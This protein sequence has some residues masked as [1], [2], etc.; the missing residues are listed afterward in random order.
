ME[1]QADKYLLYYLNKVVMLFA[2]L[3]VFFPGCTAINF[4]VGAIIDRPTNDVYEKQFKP[5][6]FHS[7]YPIKFSGKVYSGESV[8]E[9]QSC[10]GFFIKVDE[11]DQMVQL[12]HHDLTIL[13]KDGTKLFGT[14]SH[15]GYREQEPFLRLGDQSQVFAREIDSLQF[16]PVRTDSSQHFDGV[17]TYYPVPDTTYYAISGSEI[18]EF[19]LGFDVYRYNAEP[20]FIKVKEIDKVVYRKGMGPLPY[21]L[22]GVGLV[23]DVIIIGVLILVL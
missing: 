4:G 13:K 20:Y 16:Y 10:D 23:A 7:M 3:I 8:R 5:V 2:A 1:H 12:A 6:K 22:A 14:V 21:F 18:E 11:S 17:Y 15:L 19:Y 9:V